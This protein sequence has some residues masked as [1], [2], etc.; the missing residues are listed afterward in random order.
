MR[1]KGYI[2]SACFLTS[3][4]TSSI[5]SSV[6]SSSISF[7]ICCGELQ[8][9]L[10]FKG[11]VLIMSGHDSNK[12]LLY[13]GA[14]GQLWSASPTRHL[15]TFNILQLL[16]DISTYKLSEGKR[17]IY[18]WAKVQQTDQCPAHKYHWTDVLL[19]KVLGSKWPVWAGECDIWCSYGPAGGEMWQT[20]CSSWDWHWH[21]TLNLSTLM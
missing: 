4:M 6:K 16:I 20:T 9:V 21:L 12:Q 7:R 14:D 19:N 15:C 10:T 11:S 18:W 1:L 13:Q 3:A 5:S 8:L 2:F 17:S